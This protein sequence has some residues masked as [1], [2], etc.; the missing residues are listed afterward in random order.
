MPHARI[1]QA[2]LL[3]LNT[4]PAGAA[5]DA[6]YGGETLLNRALVAMSKS[7]I[8]VVTIICREGQREHLESIIHA[9]RKRLALEWKIVELKATEILS[10]KIAQA[11]EQWDDV[12]LVFEADKIL[13]PT[14][15]HQA[16]QF[17]AT[18]KPLL[19][20][21][22]NVWLREGTPFFGATFTQKFRVI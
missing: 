7:G 5:Y 19:F 11:V 2:I 20:V 17:A 6:V 9:V 3:A 4:A 15:F 1:S 14:F 8:Q 10:D 13:H 12:L 18:Q 22:K 16:V 21:Y